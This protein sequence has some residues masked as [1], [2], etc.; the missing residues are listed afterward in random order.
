[1]IKVCDAIMGS[2]KTTAAINYMNSHTDRRFIYLTPYISET[3]RIRDAC[4]DLH[5]V[6]PKTNAR[7]HT[8][9]TDSSRKLLSFGA[10]IS[11]THAAFRNYTPDMVELIKEKHYT[12]ILDECCDVLS[13][14]LLT[15]TDVDMLAEC[16]YID[17][18][19]ENAIWFS[20]GK[21][22]EN[23]KFNHEAKA[24]LSSNLTMLKPVSKTGKQYS[25][26][27][28]AIPEWLIDAFDETIILTYI[29]EGQA[30]C[31]FIRGLGLEYTKIGVVRRGALTGDYEFVDGQGD[32]PEYARHLRD[33]IDILE[34][35]KLNAIGE[36][37]KMDTNLSMNWFANNKD[38][39]GVKQLKNNIANVFKNIWT[40]STADDRMYGT[41]K[42]GAGLLRGNG[43]SKGFVTFNQRA[44]NEWRNKKYL[45]YASNIYIPGDERTYFSDRNIE[46]DADAYTLSVLV[47]WIWR[48]AIRDGKKIHLYLPSKRMRTLLYEWMDN[49]AKGGES[50]L[51]GPEEVA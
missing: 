13:K 9:K 43:Y 29:F 33:M 31:W 26:Y 49:L 42:E 38:T 32:T 36:G 22:Y 1:M 2:G 34:N 8:N 21:P 16:G 4:P 19:E 28:S 5:F 40:E 3:E 12:L 39:G 50:N 44:S 27:Y 24:L 41:F 20:T 14:T 25:I 15:K 11:S 37:A 48:S 35:D 7:E 51:G 30:L 45:A 17:Y 6:L 23:G 10:N 18:D 47:Q 46:I